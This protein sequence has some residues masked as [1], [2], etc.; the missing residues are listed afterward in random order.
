MPANTPLRSLRRIS[1]C[2]LCLLPLFYSTMTAVA[3]ILVV[4]TDGAQFM[5]GKK[6]V[7]PIS[8][9]TQIWPLKLSD[10]W[11][12]AV[13]P[14]SGAPHWIAKSSLSPLIRS[15][16]KL[17]RIKE[18]VE[19]EDVLWEYGKRSPLTPNQHDEVIAWASE[20][21]S[22][23]GDASAETGDNLVNAGRIVLRGESFREAEKLF[24][25]GLANRQRTFGANSKQAAKVHM[26]LANIYL[27]TGELVQVAK[28]AKAAAL[29]NEKLYGQD[30]PD[31]LATMIP[32][33]Q[34]LFAGSEYQDAFNIYQH[35]ATAFDEHHGAGHVQATNARARM[36]QLSKEMGKPEQALEIYRKNLIDL[37]KQSPAS[38]I[39]IAKT[40]LQIAILSIDPNDALSL[41]HV[42]EEVDRFKQEFPNHQDYAIGQNRELVSAM[43]NSGKVD[44]R[45]NAFKFADANIRH[46]RKK[47]RKELWEIPTEKQSDY[48]SYAGGH[49][50]FASISL[51]D[52]FKDDDVA[53]QRSIEW[54]I[55]AKGIVQEVQVAQAVG[56]QAERREAFANRPW[57]EL[58]QIQD[59]L[60]PDGIY[61]DILRY[62]YT[63]FREAADQRPQSRYIA[64]IVGK[65]GPPRIV[66][67]GS[68]RSLDRTIMR[69]RTTLYESVA[70][71][72][73]IG[74]RESYQILKP[75]IEKAT[76]VIWEPLRE[77]FGNAKV[78]II[79]P[80][81]A[82]W[83]LPWAAMLN[84]DGSFAIEKYQIQLELTG[85]D[86]IRPSALPANPT[87]VL[88]A[89]PDYGDVKTDDGEGFRVGE[90]GQLE[91]ASEEATAI[92]PLIAKI[93]SVQPKLL[94]GKRA[95]ESEFKKLSQPS[96][97]VFT[98]HG[99]FVNAEG[100]ILAA[101][102][103]QDSTVD[104]S[105]EI[106]KNPLLQCGL[107]L[108]DANAH[109]SI[110]SMTNDGVLTG[111]EIAG[112][113][114]RGTQLAVLSACETGLGSLDATGGVVGLRSAFHAAGTQCVL[115]SLWHVNDYSTSQMMPDFFAELVNTHDLRRAIQIAQIRQIKLRRQD[116][117]MAHPFFWAAFNLSG[118]TEF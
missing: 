110:D 115:G 113:D 18:L 31:T 111:T 81:Q 78:V 112:V 35:V 4:T 40:E 23:R 65:T 83:L 53:A 88:F 25:Q 105:V 20:I 103:I 90:F 6:V 70:E 34:A 7:A 71:V 61:V 49:E 102:G 96:I 11:V 30:H 101:G 82:T 72:E 55:N 74:E 94:V 16:E 117:G 99:F 38:P 76:K 67:L 106:A 27:E 28:S 107:A 56:L 68:A 42:R 46:L 36:A 86:L 114:L 77:N 19:Q 29:I 13:E 116:C 50:F 22:L 59:A 87:A 91:F 45:H 54:I 93:T 64:W 14:R 85:R 8:R 9:N 104:Q 98:T 48:L 89:D 95:Q 39:T 1:F 118:H 60:P 15:K 66:D 108:A 62:L 12:L 43:L 57:V 32:L 84:P 17:A 100:Q 33:A 109:T 51:A 5:D 21:R 69:L 75:A 2:F 3:Q 58:V 73:K 79:S 52:D 41:K 44:D 24:K 47:L 37:R 80:D 10:G 97:I 26:R 63:D 92:A